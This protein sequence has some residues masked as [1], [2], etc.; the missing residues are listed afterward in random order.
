MSPLATVLRSVRLQSAVISRAR[1]TG[2]W[3]VR[4]SGIPRAMV[5]HAVLTGR[6]FARR[7]VDAGIPNE[8]EPGDLVLFTRGD[9]HRVMHEAG[10]AVVQITQLPVRRTA[11]V[12]EVVGGSD[13]GET[14]RLLCGTFVLDHPASGYLIDLLPPVIVARPD[15]EARRRWAQATLALV[16]EEIDREQGDGSATVLADSLF[17]HVLS[18]CAEDGGGL[19]AAARDEQMARAIALIHRNP[20][21][22]PSVPEIAASVGMSRTRFFERFTT[23]V[24]EPPARYVARFRVFAAAD[25]LRRRTL[26]T[27]Q[28]AE[29]VGYGSED[30]LAKV[31]KRY[32]GVAPGEYRRMQASGPS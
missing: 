15:S 19:L 8:L 17:V 23:L 18:C 14:T 21:G 20:G 22:V 25:L 29:K 27:A 32:F 30:A 9:A 5:F 4:S 24:G 31:F 1:L 3:G 13:E 10:S 6:C 2:R 28:V 26:S 12:P 11:R 7:E 16:D